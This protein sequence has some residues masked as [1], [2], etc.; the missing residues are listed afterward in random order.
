MHHRNVKVMDL[1]AARILLELAGATT[2]FIILGSLFHLLGWL[3]APVRILPIV[4]AWGLLAWFSAGLGLLLGAASERSELIEK[5]WR[6]ISFVL[7]V[8]SGPTFMVDWLPPQMR[9][10]VLWVPMIHF[11]EML[12][13]GYFGPLVNVHYSLAYML[14]WCLGLSLLGMAATRI[15]N[16]DPA[17]E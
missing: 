7:F 13:G 14:A 16:R 3:A 4:F 5:I 1:F 9:E 11:V 8:L 17:L 6:P 10:A 15:V 2:S 12:R